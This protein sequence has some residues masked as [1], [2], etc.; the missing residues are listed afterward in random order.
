MPT[1]AKPQLTESP[2]AWGAAS[3]KMYQELYRNRIAILTRLRF[4]EQHDL[5]PPDA[6]SSTAPTNEEEAE[7]RQI[8][9]ALTVAAEASGFMSTAVLVATLQR[10]LKNPSLFL[11]RELPAAIEWALAGGYQRANEP[12]GTHWRDV[13]GDQ[14][15]RFPGEVEQPTESNIAK[16]ASAA[17]ATIQETREPGRNYNVADQIL[18][19]QLGEIFRGSGQSIRRQTMPIMRHGKAVYVEGGGPFYDFLELVLKPLQRYLKERQLAPVTVASIVRLVTDD[20]PPS[21]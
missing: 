9:S 10:V 21:S 6:N 16:A 2:S 13:L 19:E 3:D 5:P 8:A 14:V 11:R 15:S 20:S 12:P 7:L 17:L 4:Y 1:L 18:A